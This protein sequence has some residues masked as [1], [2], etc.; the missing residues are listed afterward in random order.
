MVNSEMLY[1]SFK[2]SCN[3][4]VLASYAVVS[5]HYTNIAIDEY[6]KDYCEH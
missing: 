5:N 2:Q 1:S 6:F 3:S 4:C